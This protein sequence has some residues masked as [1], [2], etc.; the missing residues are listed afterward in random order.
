VALQTD[1]GGLLTGLASAESSGALMAT[2]SCNCPACAAAGEGGNTVGSYATTPTDDAYR[3]VSQAQS[4]LSGSGGDVAALMAGSKWT[5]LDSASAKTV[6]TFSFADPLTSSFAYSTNDFQSSLTSF[7]SA[8]RQLT[9]DLLAKIESVCN[10]QFVEVADNASECGVIRYGYSKEPN[11][12]NFAGYAFFPS[13]G[14]IGGD[15]WIGAN[16]ARP[17][18][19]FYRPDLIL[20]E[21]LHALGLKHPFSTGAVLSTEQDI[22]PNT[23]MSYSTLAGSTAGY[24]SKYPGEPMALDIAALQ[25]LYGAS[26]LNAGDTRYDLASA[27]F[28]SGFHA[29]W[30]AGG[31][32]VLDASHVGRGVSLDLNAGASSNIGVSVSATGNVAGSSVSTVYNSTFTVALGA[33]IEDAVGSAFNDVLIGNGAA[34]RLEGGAGN[35]RLEGRGGNDV[36]AGG[37]GSNTLDGGD[38][39]DIAV[40]ASSRDSYTIG[41]GAQG[42]VVTGANST[43]S[44]SGIERL[45][46]S[47][48]CVA[49]DVSGNAG[50][51]AKVIGVVFGAH[52]VENAGYMGVAVNLLDAGMSEQD[53]V[54]LGL[55]FRLGA[56]AGNEAVV[57]LLY[58]NLT[59]AAPAA[60]DKDFYVGLL[61][62]GV[63]S[64]ACL[65]QL[66]AETALNAANI[67]LVGLC[68]SGIEYIG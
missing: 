39:M 3:Y 56:G 48:G 31:T 26:A 65:G 52:C 13:S 46:F 67:D 7:S 28:Q 18:W 25:Y 44:L 22:I 10:V 58:A 12:M 47:D 34:N 33:V 11:A 37:A 61:D 55:D 40:F 2:L 64:Q 50:T 62:Q 5:S 17:E 53:L 43:D 8:D 19:D 21:T 27:S 38:G 4:P 15:V 60:T 24:M 66:A 6:I 57:D 32:D 35:D 23:V 51:A 45:V 20:H 42:V 63:F 16:Q 54:H 36:L 59:G 14:A 30:D 1:S 41:R 29:V 9:R 49:L 68:N